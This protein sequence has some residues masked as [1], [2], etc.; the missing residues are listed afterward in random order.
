MGIISEVKCGRCDR[1]YSGFRSRC[2]YCG[3]RRNKRGK[4]ANDSDNAKAKLVIG[5]LLMLVL[6]A[7]A[8]VLIISSLPP[9]NEPEVN[10]TASPEA[11]DSA[12]PTYNDDDGVVE[13]P[14]TSAS[15]EPSP[16]ET[17]SPDVSEIPVESVQITYAGKEVTD[18]TLAH[19]GD[20]ENLKYKTVP[21]ETTAEP[22]WKCSDE[23]VIMF[24]ENET[25]VKVTAVGSGVATLTLTIGG[26]SA[27]CIVRV[28]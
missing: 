24:V 8:M 23:S 15:I 4:H 18:F 21:A 11:T 9:D 25:G 5:T 17:E 3:A 6:I 10:N 13:E 22:E 2:P 26:K 1:R 16:E 12:E 20:Y 7:A 28:K 14:G 27:E 19:L